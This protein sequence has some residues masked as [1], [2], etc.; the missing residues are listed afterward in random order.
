MSKALRRFLKERPGRDE[1]DLLLVDLKKGG[2]RGAAVLAAILIDDVLESA[3][4]YHMPNLSS[5]ED[6]DLLLGL[7]AHSVPSLREY[8]S[9]M[10][11]EFSGRKTTHDL[12]VLREIRNAMAHGRRAITFKTPEVTALCKS[13]HCL[14]TIPD[15]TQAAPRYLFNQA[16]TKLMHH[17]V[18]K[19]G[20]Y[21]S[22]IPTKSYVTELD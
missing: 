7:T 8:V 19:I 15:F 9:L 13:F 10:L 14:N 5:V 20:P 17:L 22:D 16:V 4:K 11:L 18:T 12:N 6:V 3:L 21:P 2:D 1:V